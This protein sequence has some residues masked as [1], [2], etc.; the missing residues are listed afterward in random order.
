MAYHHRLNSGHTASPFEPS[1]RFDTFP[2]PNTPRLPPLNAAV[3]NSQG[4]QVE[5]A[6]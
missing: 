2:N 4:N 3:R 1:A 5:I 6:I